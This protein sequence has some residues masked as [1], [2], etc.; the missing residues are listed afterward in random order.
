LLGEATVVDPAAQTIAATHTSQKWAEY[1]QAG[2][3]RY[4]E[5][6]AVSRAQR[7]QKYELLPVGFSRGGGELTPTLK[8]RRNIV[9]EKYAGL[10]DGMYQPKS[11]L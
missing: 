11:S 8:L 4:N 6:G 9:L 10:I 2:I 3:D 7:I 5:T 1:I